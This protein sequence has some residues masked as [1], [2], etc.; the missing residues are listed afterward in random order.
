MAVVDA[1]PTRFPSNVTINRG[2]WLGPQTEA[3]RGAVFAT[4]DPSRIG[5]TNRIPI[6][7]TFCI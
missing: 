6:E 5:Q 4:P 1:G 7:S 3:G 2:P